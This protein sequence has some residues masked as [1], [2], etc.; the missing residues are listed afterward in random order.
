MIN[1]S[2][3]ELIRFH[4]QMED[5]VG[6][7]VEMGYLYYENWLDMFQE[8]EIYNNEFELSSITDS[9]TLSLVIL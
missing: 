3:F 9:D 1:P 8:Y 7:F 2:D 6:D 5:D 4:I